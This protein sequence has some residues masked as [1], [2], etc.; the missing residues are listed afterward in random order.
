MSPKWIDNDFVHGHPP[1]VAAIPEIT[2]KAWF[3]PQFHTA[4]ERV[5]L[6]GPGSSVITNEENTVENELR[7]LCLSQRERDQANRLAFDQAL[8]RVLER[9]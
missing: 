4:R 9:P 5:T 8:P 7:K 6:R 2:W 1:N 3:F